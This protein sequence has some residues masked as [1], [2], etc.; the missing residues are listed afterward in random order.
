MVV[1]SRWWG[2]RNPE[3]AA[4][5]MQ[6]SNTDTTDH[7]QGDEARAQLAAIVESSDD[8]IIVRRLDGTITAWNPGAERLYG[9][10]AQEAIG[11]A[12]ALLVP[13]DRA[14]ELPAV[15]ERLARGERIDHY[16]TVR[17]GKDG[18]RLEVSIGVS[19]I[20][21]GTGRV[22]AA[23]I[24]ARDITERQQAR[25]GHALL[26]RASAIL[27]SSLDADLTL[28]SVAH[29]A[30]PTLAD[31]CLI[32]LMTETGDLRRLI[33]AATAPTQPDTASTLMRVDPL[34]AV[35][36]QAEVELLR[37]GQ[38]MLAADAAD[39]LPAWLS[40]SLVPLGAP[41]PQ[42]PRGA[43]I[44]PLL[45]RGRTLGAL[46]L[47]LA[48][49]DRRY[50][51]ADLT[52]AEELAGR[53]A[54]AVDSAQLYREAQK[55]L[56]R[57]RTA[58]IRAEA[59][60]A[61]RAA[62]LRQIADGVMIA[63]PGGHLTFANEA[64]RQLFGGL[65]LG[66]VVSHAA[67]ARVLTPDGQPFPPA[68]LPLARA[69]RD[70]ETV[71]DALLRLCRPDGS[72]VI[73]QGH[74]AP[75]VA[76]DGR[77]LGAVMTLRDVTA[78][79]QFER[80]K[81][82][83]FASVSHDLRTPLAG[84][85]ASIG[86]VLAH[87]PTQLPA[88]LH[89]L[90][91]NINQTVD[92]MSGLVNDLLELTR[93]Q[94]GRAEVRREPG[95][96]RQVVKRAVRTIEPLAQSRGQQVHLAL[97]RQPVIVEADAGRLE[98]AVLNLLGNAHTHGHAGGTIQ[99]RLTRQAAAAIISVSDDG[100][101][102]APEDQQHLFERFYRA[103]PARARRRP[104]SGLGLA[105]ARAMVELHGGRIWVTSTAGAGATFS[106]AVPLEGTGMTAREEPP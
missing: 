36:A 84:I 50:G 42:P 89:R 95:D 91:S 2:S 68:T 86:V 87:P 97:P 92:Q 49:A 82:D 51:A 9:Y 99:V 41:W 69:A 10:T 17:V 31:A 74:A 26:A 73:V 47:I 106:I 61:E 43:L 1:A 35:A 66:V 32:D 72:E 53:I 54:L 79:H 29:L 102:I 37:L 11:Q 16:E 15:F 104:G 96:L 28:Q 19:P 90:L 55:A 8:A 101:G 13:P 34:P 23:A 48:R 67:A 44:V 62:V 12:I 7:H 33:V 3:G 21:D 52:L 85:K 30:V 58:R 65:T 22:T 71:V 24:I 78:R 75:V 5:A 93:V 59:L 103:A 25:A 6:G 100:P 63:D 98:R 81:D 88:P 57:E 40:Q 77:R 105:I 83:F 14:A 46:T 56:V 80:E 76:D 38:P 45:A 18:Q 60:A 70:G 4:S 94:A 27:A 39:P 64:A 20:R